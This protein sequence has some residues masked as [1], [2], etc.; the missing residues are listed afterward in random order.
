MSRRSLAIVIST[1]LALTVSAA[2]AYAYSADRAPT[3]LHLPNGFQPEGI[4]IGDAPYA[5]F[6]SRVDGDIYRVSL[7]TGKGKV[8]SQ[9]PGTQS[10]GLNLDIA[11]ASSC[12]AAPAATPG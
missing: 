8:I 2:P 4:A 9:G 11:T 7:R 10:L 3:T 6:G 12:P 5:Y 1:V